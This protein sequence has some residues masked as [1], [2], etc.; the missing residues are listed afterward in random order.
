M[1]VPPTTISFMLACLS[2]DPA[3]ALRPGDWNCETGRQTRRWLREKEMIDEDNRPTKKGK[4]WINNICRTPLS[5]D[6]GG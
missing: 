2:S 4:A 1:S 6:L 5:P 3:S